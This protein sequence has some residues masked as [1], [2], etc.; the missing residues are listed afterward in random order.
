MVDNCFKADKVILLLIFKFKEILCSIFVFIHNVRVL[1]LF[2]P[3]GTR[4]FARHWV[5]LRVLSCP[6]APGDDFLTFGT[7]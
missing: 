2:S 4:L 5:L 3:S 1:T 7:L 6:G